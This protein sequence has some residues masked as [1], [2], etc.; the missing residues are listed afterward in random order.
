MRDA[1]EILAV[2]FA[3]GLVFSLGQDTWRWFS[4]RYVK[5]FHPAEKIVIE[6]DTKQALDAIAD[7]QAAID[8]LHASE[9]SA[10]GAA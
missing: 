6:V 1:I 2:V 3:L 8:K 10:K 7:L 9:S 4:A 5:F